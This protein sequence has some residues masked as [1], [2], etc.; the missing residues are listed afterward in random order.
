MTPF[1][2]GKVSSKCRVSPLPKFELLP[3]SLTG[4]IVFAVSDFLKIRHISLPT[5]EYRINGG[6]NNRERGWKWF[7]KAIIWGVGFS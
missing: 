4:N 6:E 5:L 3:E 1:I 7:D 2:D